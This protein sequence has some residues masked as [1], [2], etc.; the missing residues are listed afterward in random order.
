MEDEVVLLNKDIKRYTQAAKERDALKEKVIIL[1]QGAQKKKEQYY[2]ADIKNKAQ[3]KQ[4][5]KTLKTVKDNAEKEAKDTNGELSR[6]Q[7]RNKVLNDELSKL[8]EENKHGGFLIKFTLF[9]LLA[10]GVAIGIAAGAMTYMG[11]DI[12]AQAMLLIDQAA[13]QFIKNMISSVFKL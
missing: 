9:I 2:Q 10:V 11:V 6:E 1:S 7:L 12:Q 4:L 3:L 8:R 5:E 13:S